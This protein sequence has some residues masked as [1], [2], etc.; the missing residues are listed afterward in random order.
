MIDVQQGALR[1]LEQ[2]VGAGA[3]GIVERT[4]HIGDHPG[5]ARSNGHRSIVNLLKIHRLGPM[6]VFQHEVVIFKYLAE[7]LGKALWLGKVL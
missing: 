6:V 1:A 3:V 4:R 2:Q 7:P 5:Q